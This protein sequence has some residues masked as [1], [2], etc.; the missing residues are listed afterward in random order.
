MMNRTKDLFIRY[1]RENKIDM[2]YIVGAKCT[3]GVVL[4]G[5][6]KITLGE[7][8][9]HSYAK[10]IFSPLTSIVIGSSGASGMYRTFQARL[11]LGVQDIGREKEGQNVFGMRK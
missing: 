6:K 10:K 1:L 4:V 3:D 8:T 9:E 5:D 11:L 2:T 7:G